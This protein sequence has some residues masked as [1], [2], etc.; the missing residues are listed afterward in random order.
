MSEIVRRASAADAS[1]SGQVVFENSL[2]EQNGCDQP[3]GLI[4]L[5]MLVVAAGETPKVLH[6]VDGSLDAIAQAV[7]RHIERPI[8]VP[9]RA[10]S[11]SNAHTALTQVAPN[12]RIAV[13]LGANDVVRS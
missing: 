2:P 3:H 6:P 12:D 8:T 11:D 1:A 7:D 13:A 9:I 5:D 4:V 10:E